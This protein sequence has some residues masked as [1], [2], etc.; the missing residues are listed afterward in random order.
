MTYI[1]NKPL[2]TLRISA[3]NHEQYIEQAVMSLVNQTYKNIEIIVLDDGSKDKTPEII[4][5][6]ANKYNFTFIQQENKGLTYSLNRLNGMANGKYIAGCAS[7]DFI[8]LEKVEKQVEFLENHNYFAV[9]SG[10]AVN[11][12]K[13]GKY[14]RRNIYED[15]TFRV[16]NFEDV[17]LHDKSIP[18]G[19]AMIRKDVLQEVG[20]YSTDYPIEDK[21]MWLK[22]TNKG[23]K[24]AR[25]N[26]LLQYYRQHN[27]NISGNYEFIIE[28]IKKCLD[29]YKANELYPRAINN[30]YTQ[31]F[32]NY[33]LLSKE[34]SINA[35][36]KIKWHM[37]DT[38]SLK[39][40]ILGVMKHVKRLSLFGS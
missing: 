13:E 34:H 30:F 25:M 29:M 12:D 6:L 36:H 26:T 11:V 32:N 21:Y 24:I 23:Y 15:G 22:I 35:F 20:G 31:T 14:E 39:Q 8:P 7:D 16:I 17:F 3:Y 1:N 2:V 18:A 28:N 40:I 10:N 37:L 4:Q 5:K 27:S 38:D 19:T 9:C 33:A